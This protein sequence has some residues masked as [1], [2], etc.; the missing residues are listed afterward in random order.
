MLVNQY[1]L[2]REAHEYWTLK[3][4]NSESLGG[5]FDPLPSQAA[6]NFRCVSHP[7]EPVFGPQTLQGKLVGDRYY[8]I[9]TQELTRIHCQT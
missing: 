4:N 7:D 6:S 2:T 9:V 5:L 8:D 1:A 3:K